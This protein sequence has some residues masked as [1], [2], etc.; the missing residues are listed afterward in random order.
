MLD[1]RRVSGI[2][3]RETTLASY[4]KV[5]PWHDLDFRT[6]F[7]AGLLPLVWDEPVAQALRQI[8]SMSKNR[9]SEVFLQSS[10]MYDRTP[11]SM[12]RRAI[13]R[14]WSMWQDPEWK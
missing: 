10:S 4:Q 6:A 9:Q 1:L 2:L 13:G 14:K 12:A 5:R 7:R 11:K 3:Q 8:I